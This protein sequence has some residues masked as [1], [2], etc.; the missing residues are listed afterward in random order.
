MDQ[1][2]GIIYTLTSSGTWE[3]QGPIVSANDSNT[4][5]A[6]TDGGAYLASTILE[7][8]ITATAT[9]R[10]LRPFNTLLQINYL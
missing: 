9:T 1:S 5:T 2:T 3:K 8:L 6:G 7:N 10:S 4:L